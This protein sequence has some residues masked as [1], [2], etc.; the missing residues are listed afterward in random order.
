MTED[1]WLAVACPTCDAQPGHRCKTATGRPTAAHTTRL[2]AAAPKLT[3][4]E[5]AEREHEYR[6]LDEQYS[7]RTMVTVAF[8]YTCGCTGPRSEPIPLRE[9]R[10]WPARA[11]I[12]DDHDEFAV[13]CGVNVRLIA[14]EATM[15][16][17]L[18]AADVPPGSAE[19]VAGDQNDQ[20]RW[21]R[22][23]RGRDGGPS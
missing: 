5:V 8:E 7:L 14:D 10:T 18:L 19:Y 1:R 9:A 4:E 16:R 23:S 17:I 22:M 11:V 6:Q 13:T 15:L 21:K 3:A 12:C 20:A 2:A